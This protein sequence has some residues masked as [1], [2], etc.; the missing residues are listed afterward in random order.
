MDPD[1]SLLRGLVGDVEEFASSVWGIRPLHRASGRSFE[2]LLSVGAIERLLTSAARRPTF[3]LVRDGVTLPPDRSTRTVRMAGAVLDDVAD[4]GR[5][6]AAVDEGATLV[7]QGLQRTTVELA[8]LCRS[9]ERATSHPV[10][11]TAYLTPPGAAGLALHH[12]EHDVLVLQ[13]EGTKAWD[14]AGPGPLRLVP[15]DV[16]YLPTGTR[17]AAAAQ[18][19]MSLHLT[20]GLL[21]ITWGDVVR[22]LVG[23]MEGMSRPL[24][25]GYARSG[26][27]AGEVREVLERT[28]RDLLAAD[29]A[30]VAADEVHRAVTRRRP[31]P[32][33]Q[34][35]SVLAL[36]HLTGEDRI[37]RRPDHPAAIDPRPGEDGR[38][39]LHLV[40]RELLFPQGARPAV[41]QLL[42]AD[43]PVR[44]GDLEDLEPHGQLVLARRLVR[45]G[46]VVVVDDGG[47]AP[48]PGSIR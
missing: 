46:L 12:D 45:E 16:L 30:A 1:L 48:L 7:L 13:I 5:I 43:G 22:R 9:L 14:V 34:L 37:L 3:R 27:F 8:E 32:L 17:H 31:L 38:C 18:E 47:Q 35:R 23:D 6:A 29:P 19:G 42:A 2:D 21:R 26:S 15:G 24:P 41:E 28:A 44:V 20:L 10:Q 40:D 39:V 33:G 4:L 25:L 36:P 11:A